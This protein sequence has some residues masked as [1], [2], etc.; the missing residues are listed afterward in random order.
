VYMG[1]LDD[2]ASTQLLSEVIKAANVQ[3]VFKT[4][5]TAATMK[6]TDSRAAAYLNGI[7]LGTVAHMSGAPARYMSC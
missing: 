4:E 1:P 6:D 2:V 5:A 3:L 7:C